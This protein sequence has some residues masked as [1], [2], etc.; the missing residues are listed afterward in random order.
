[1]SEIEN[2]TSVAEDDEISLI[3]LFSVLVRHRILIVFGT[4]AVFFVA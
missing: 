3:D 4:V 1:M 2:T